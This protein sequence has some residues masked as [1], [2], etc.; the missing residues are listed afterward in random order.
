MKKTILGLLV[1]AGAFSAHAQYKSEVKFNIA[2]VIAIE[3][4]EIGYEYFLDDN[5][6]IGAE[7]HI[8]D[9]FSYNTEKKGKKFDTN[10]FF[11]ELQL[12][13]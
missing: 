2:N 6:S 1:F 5:Q 4:V 3:S 7:L 13:F 12:L 11:T 10:S 9:R 8:N